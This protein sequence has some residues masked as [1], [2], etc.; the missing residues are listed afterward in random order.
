MEEKGW[1]RVEE[2]RTYKVGKDYYA[3][4]WA[5]ISRRRS[6][7]SVCKQDTEVR[8]AWAVC[9]KLSDYKHSVAERPL[10]RTCGSMHRLH[11][12][13]GVDTGPALR[14][15]IYPLLRHLLLCVFCWD[16]SPLCSKVVA[17]TWQSRGSHRAQSW[18]GSCLRNTNWA[19]L[20]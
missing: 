17:I 5:D 7:T 19:Q 3:D 18:A 15:T 13:V 4:I 11:F 8:A 10:R 1:G 14:K 6:S 2:N 12:G 9:L 16:M 20:W